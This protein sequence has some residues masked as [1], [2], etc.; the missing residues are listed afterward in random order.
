M[1]SDFKAGP[2]KWWTRAPK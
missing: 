1:D 2:F